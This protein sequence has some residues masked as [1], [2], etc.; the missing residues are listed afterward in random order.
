MSWNVDAVRDLAKR[1]ET[2]CR[3]GDAA[4]IVDL[5]SED[6]VIWYNYE[7]V[8]HDKAAYRKILE[9]SADVFRNPQYRD[10]RVMLHPGGFV[11]QATL[12]GET[13]KG[14]IE[15]PFC[16]VA[17]VTDGKISRIEE[18]FDSTIMRD[19]G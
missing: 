2:A 16:L 15:T 6:A 7:G 19:P 5:V 1:W 14:M 9:E 3:S 17:T 13:D 18:Y 4:A 11:E 12:V 10:F 8:E